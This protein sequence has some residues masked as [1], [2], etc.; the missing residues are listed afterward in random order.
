MHEN[1]TLQRKIFAPRGPASVLYAHGN[2][3]V[4]AVAVSVINSIDANVM[5]QRNR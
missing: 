3:D 4:I 1:T 5:P 2:M